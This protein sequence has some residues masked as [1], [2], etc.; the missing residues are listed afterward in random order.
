[1]RV[2]QL[3]PY[4]P[5][6]GGVQTNLVA[7]RRL[8]RARGIPCAV[9]NITSA[10][11]SGDDEVYYPRGVL[12]LLRLFRVLRYD[13]VHL[14]L[15]GNLTP[16]LLGLAA[17]CTM[18]PG[19]KS[20]LTFHSGGYPS[21]PEGR[22]ARAASLR[23]AVFRRFDRIIV[24]NQE[25]ADLFRRFGCRADAIRLILPHESP[26][27]P[28]SDPAA[29]LPPPLSNFVAA[30]DRLLTTVGLLEPEYDLARQIEVFPRIQAAMP[31]AGLLI[32]GSGSLEGE[33]RARIARSPASAHICLAGD[34]PHDQALRAIAASRVFLRTTL[35]DGDSI[36]V[37]EA[38]ALGTPVVATDTGMRPDGV[39]L[40]PIGDSE[41]LI[42]AAAAAMAA[43]RSPRTAEDT[44][45][46]EAVLELYEEL[47]G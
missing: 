13:V 28:Q 42:E 46:I 33:L 5:P 8:L 25:L 18:L 32:I 19:A 24:V 27:L 20:V 11:E 34:V 2:L 30:H 22:T 44:G 37:R 16:R 15:G 7:I 10:P 43:P 12:P 39:R 29:E 14:H 36:S 21:S 4:P 47:A 6:H 31:G 35:Y 1:M 17:V 3:G 38:L 40:V 45:N 26:A 9:I 23:G 41:A